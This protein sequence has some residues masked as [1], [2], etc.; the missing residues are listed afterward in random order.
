LEPSSKSILTAIP[1]PWNEKPSMRRNFK[2]IETWKLLPHC[3]VP[4]VWPMDLPG[5][6]KQSSNLVKIVS[7]MRGHPMEFI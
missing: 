4:G 1:F 3:L 7:A 5:K 6:L 2:E